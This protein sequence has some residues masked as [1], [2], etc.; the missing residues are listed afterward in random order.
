MAWKVDWFADKVMAAA[1]KG[2]V[3]GLHLA[4]TVMVAEIKASLSVPYPPS[5]EP[6]APPHRRSGD[7]KAG[8]R[9]RVDAANLVVYVLSTA[10]WATYL[11]YGTSRM[12]PRPYLRR[13]LL[14]YAAEHGAGHFR[15][16]TSLDYRGGPAEEFA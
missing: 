11:E 9:Y 5:S 2:A 6:Y 7:L 8:I 15:A 3:A 12:A 13:G 10:A 1:R 4:G 14:G 16:L